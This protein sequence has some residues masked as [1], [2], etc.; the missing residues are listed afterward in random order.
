M[1]ESGCL[2]YEYY[3]DNLPFRRLMCEMIENAIKNAQGLELSAEDGAYKRCKHD[4]KQNAIAYLLS[5]DFECD[6]ELLGLDSQVETV[7]KM[8]T[9]NTYQIP[10]HKYAPKL[11]PEQREEIRERYAKGEKKAEL[12]RE[13]GVHYASVRDLVTA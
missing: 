9:Q 6:M 8:V 13:Y 3:D 2:G 5:D 4:V 11:Q 10:L 1:S 12:A 7:R